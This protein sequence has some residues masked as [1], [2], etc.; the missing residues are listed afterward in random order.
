MDEA[1]CATQ[2]INFDERNMTGSFLLRADDVQCLVTVTRRGILNAASPPRASAA[3]FAECL[4]TFRA[5]ALEKLSERGRREMLELTAED[6]RRWRRRH[7][8]SLPG[9]Y[10]AKPLR[11]ASVV[12]LD[13]YRQQHR[14][15]AICHRDPH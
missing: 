14:A 10:S 15:R 6:V 1:P 9:R 12:S 11:A 7:T 2:E 5:V 8:P 4:E 3:H 13:E